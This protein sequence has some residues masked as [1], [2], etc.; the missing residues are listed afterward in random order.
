MPHLLTL[1]SLSRIMMFRNKMPSTN[2]RHCPHTMRRRLFS[3]VLLSPHGLLPVKK[4]NALCCPDFPLVPLRFC[5]IH[6]QG[7]ALHPKQT[8]MK[9]DVYK[10][11][12]VRLHPDD[13]ILCLT[14]ASE[15]HSSSRPFTS[16][17]T[18][19][20]SRPFTSIKTSPSFDSSNSLE[21]SSSSPLSAALHSDPATI[22]Q[23]MNR[24]S[25]L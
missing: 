11:R 24:I 17:K 5:N 14:G 6:R 12:T 20:S 2:C 1:T 21:R 22:R 13:T 23:I 19:S 4:R 16:I 9:N 15:I 3:S 25:N 8:N 10:R 7:Q 18:P